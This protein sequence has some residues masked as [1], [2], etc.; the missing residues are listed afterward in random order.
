MRE[1]KYW[2]AVNE[3]LFEEMT[4]DERVTPA[5]RSARAGASSRSSARGA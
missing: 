3:A 5:D 1:L 2:Q 4:R